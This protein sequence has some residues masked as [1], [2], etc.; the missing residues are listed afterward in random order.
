MSITKEWLKIFWSE[1]YDFQGNFSGF[2][3]KK[4]PNFENLVD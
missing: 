3:T 1:I 2:S 4:R